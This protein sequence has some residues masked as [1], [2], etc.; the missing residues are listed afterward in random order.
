MGML[1]FIGLL[2]QCRL[3][4][5]AARGTHLLGSVIQKLVTRL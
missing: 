3:A 4:Y 1:K 5:G 2:L